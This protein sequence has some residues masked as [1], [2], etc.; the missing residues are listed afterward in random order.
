MNFE[1]WLGLILGSALMYIWKEFSHARQI[2]KEQDLQV[3][4]NRCTLEA[5]RHVA[6]VEL[7]AISDEKLVRGIAAG[8][9]SVASRTKP[10]G[11]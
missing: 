2:A 1:F 5:V 6:S 11:E 8:I 4:L 7:N 9:L 3:R 10:D